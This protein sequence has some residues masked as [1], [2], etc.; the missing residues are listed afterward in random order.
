MCVC[1]RARARMCV[2]THAYKLAQVEAFSDWL[3]V[4]LGLYIVV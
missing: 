2:C 4:S 1:A 3:A